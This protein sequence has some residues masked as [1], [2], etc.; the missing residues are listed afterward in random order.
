MQPR[1]RESFERLETSRT[2]VL[3]GLSGLETETLNRSPGPGRWSALQVLHHVVTA[4]ALTV[5]YVRKK[6]QAGGSLPRAG[7]VSRLRLLALRAALAS[8]LRIRAPA[9]TASV[10][11]TSELPAIEARWAEVRRELCAL[12]EA[13]PAEAAGRTVFR[14]PLVGLMGIEETLGFLQAHLD[15][16]AR[17]VAA[18]AV[19]REG[20][21]PR[22]PD[23]SAPRP[24]PSPAG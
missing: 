5:S 17:Q 4:E 11:A 23:S 12:L 24:R 18:A 8:P 20:R 7:L 22:P 14:H 19:P 6:A 10:P 2:R 13:F 15:H 16:H 9:A 21:E 3:A 1:L